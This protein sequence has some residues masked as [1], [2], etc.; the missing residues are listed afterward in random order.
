MSQRVTLTIPG[1]LYALLTQKRG[2]QTDQEYIL[3]AIDSACNGSAVEAELRRQID[4]LH[5]TIRRLGSG[6]PSSQAAQPAPHEPSPAE[7]L[8]TGKPEPMGW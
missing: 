5:E 2:I 7:P 8:P 1:G 6:S 3:R 4:L